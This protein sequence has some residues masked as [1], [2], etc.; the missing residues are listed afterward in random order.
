MKGQRILWVDDEGIKSKIEMLEDKGFNVIYEQSVDNALSRILDNNEKFDVILIDIMMECPDKL[1]GKCRSDGYET[2]VAFLEE[3]RNNAKTI[4]V[5]VIT[6]NPSEEVKSKCYSIGISGF[7][8]KPIS[9]V[10]LERTI[11]EIVCGK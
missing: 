8:S 1:K 5:I 11:D 2:G 7:L 3:I 10:E 9:Q 6:G 4:P